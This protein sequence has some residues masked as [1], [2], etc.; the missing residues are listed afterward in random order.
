MEASLAAVEKLQFLGATVS[1]ITMPS[2]QE[3]LAS[4]KLWT[5][6]LIVIQAEFK[7]SLT[8][9]LQTLRNTSIHT[10]QDLIA[11][12]LDSA[13]EM[14]PGH[15]CQELFIEA[16][17]AHST[18]SPTYRSALHVI[19]SLARGHGIDYALHT[20]GV[21][22]LVVPTEAPWSSTLAAMAGYPIATAPLGYINESGRPFGLSFFAGA[23]REEMLIRV[24]GAWE[25]ES[26]G[27]RA[28]KALSALSYGEGSMRLK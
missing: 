17:T 15:C 18:E 12:N 8:S 22:V 14:P 25:K 4:P 5:N 16:L 24:L 3:A 10:L 7:E 26:G 13:A 2:A 6:Q 11:F 9:H 23:G 21:D 1:D 28:P 19:Q 20:Y 27:R